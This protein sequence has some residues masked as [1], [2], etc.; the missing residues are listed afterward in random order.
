MTAKNLEKRLETLQRAYKRL[1]EVLSLNMEETDIVIDATIQRFEF[2]FELAWKTIKEFAETL[3][4]GECNSGRSCIKLAYKLGWIKDEKK[5]L[6]LLEARNLTSH[7]YD[8]EIALE[9]YLI[10]KSEHTAFE[11]LILSL[12]KELENLVSEES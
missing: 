2:T 9:T 1:K 8:Q 4:A 12:K 5:W 10:I 6:S 7:T 11:N 3:R